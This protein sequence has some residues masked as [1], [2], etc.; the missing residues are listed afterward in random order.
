MGSDEPQRPMPIEPL[1]GQ[2]SSMFLW[3]RLA[4]HVAI[5]IAV[6]IG[7]AVFVAIVLLII[8]LPPALLLGDF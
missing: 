8:T 1:P 3:L 6:L 4:V 2:P 7:V 5:S